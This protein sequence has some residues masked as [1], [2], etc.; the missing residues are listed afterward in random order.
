MPVVAMPVCWVTSTRLAPCLRLPEV[1]PDDQCRSGVLL[2]PHLLLGPEDVL[3]AGYGHVLF[4]DP[5]EE[6]LCLART[7]WAPTALGPGGAPNPARRRNSRNFSVSRW[8]PL[9]LVGCRSHPLS[10]AGYHF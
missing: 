9:V 10:S 1:S 3:E 8:H 5:D 2:P 6:F 7:A 4:A